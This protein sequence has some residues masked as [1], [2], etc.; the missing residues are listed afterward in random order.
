M[1][2][3]RFFPGQP[4]CFESELLCE[5]AGLSSNSSLQSSTVV[6]CGFMA[7]HSSYPPFAGWGSPPPPPHAS[8]LTRVGEDVDR[9]TSAV[10][11]AA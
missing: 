8:T 10:V 4:G 5:G 3:G 7:A 11:S 2:F 1:H 6:P 9:T